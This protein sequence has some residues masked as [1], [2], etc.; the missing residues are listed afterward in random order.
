[1]RTRSAIVSWFIAGVILMLPAFGHAQEATLSGTIT[2]STGGVLPGVTV[3]AV[4]EATGNMYES[5]T[6]ER[7]GF[8][9][10]VRVGTFT[11]SAQLAGFATTNR[12]VVL[13]VGQTAAVNIQLAPSQV[14]ETVTVTGQAPLIDTTAS[15]LGSNIDPKQVSELPVL[16]RSWTDLTLLAVGNRENNVD[17][18]A[19]GLNIGSGSVQIHLDGQ[20]ITQVFNPANGQHRVSR[21]GIAEFEYITSRFDA[22]KGRSSAVP[23][24]AIT[25]SGTNVNS[26]TF[27]GYFRS[28]KF[29]AA[30][31]IAGYVLPYSNQAVSTTFG[32]PIQR[33]RLHYFAY[34]EYEREPKT[35]THPTPF[36]TFNVD[37]QGTRIG[38][39]PGVRVDY[40]RSLN[41]R[42]S[43]RSGI[44]WREVR[45][46]KGR[47]VA[48]NGI[49]QQDSRDRSRHRPGLGR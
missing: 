10:P 1:M 37:L 42:L 19:P 45:T 36:P 27:S 31:P 29:N 39:T 12:T 6:D 43:F 3:T 11:I 25:K 16:G 23:V 38:H 34:Y 20:Q 41:T 8:R 9:M 5:V 7:G 18:D 44:A 40:Q 26:G 4:H 2:D 35:F 24:N 28:D 49:L 21:D 46:R 15:T 33:D 32:G 48:R 14:Q 13:L 30:D 17:A 47:L 22:T